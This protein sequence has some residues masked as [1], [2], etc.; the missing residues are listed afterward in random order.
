MKIRR[1]IIVGFV[2]VSLSVSLVACG[3]QGQTPVPPTPTLSATPVPAP[4]ATP[5]PAP[6]ATPVP[7]PPPPTAV[8]QPSI[9]FSADTDRVPEGQCTNLHWN[10][11]QAKAVYLQYEG[12][13]EGVPGQGSQ[14]VCPS[15]DGKR[16]V[17][18]VDGLD[19]QQHTNEI[20]INIS[21]PAVAIKFWSDQDKVT[22]G[23]C[24]VVR[25]DVS[26]SKE[27]Q[28]NDGKGWNDVSPNGSQQ[29]C[30]AYPTDYGLRVTDLDGKTHDR[31]LK[32]NTEAPPP[33]LITPTPGTPQPDA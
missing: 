3:N 8:P 4:S 2:L 24:T 7:P 9:S 30:P 26:N 1:L 14:Q 6:S 17:L 31:S 12:K 11:D 33:G 32:I 16:Y 20:Q 28:F 5:V 29:V 22:I 19:G 13:T 25:W 15:S 27:V 10:V 21:K 23:T 18:V